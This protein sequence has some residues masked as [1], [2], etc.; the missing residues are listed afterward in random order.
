MVSPVVSLNREIKNWM[1]KETQLPSPPLDVAAWKQVWAMTVALWTDSVSLLC[2]GVRGAFTVLS[3]YCHYSAL[4]QHDPVQGF[5]T[6]SEVQSSWNK[7]S[8][9]RPDNELLNTLQ[10]L[11]IQYTVLNLAQL[12]SAI[13]STQFCTGKSSFLCP[14]S[15]GGVTVQPCRVCSPGQTCPQCTGLDLE[16]SLKEN[17]T[18]VSAFIQSLERLGNNKI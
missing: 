3:I 17:R 4:L 12:K 14:S 10:T 13:F 8:I 16:K 11:T 15:Q 2:P 5:Y 7:F 1:N 6:N 9:S 18:S